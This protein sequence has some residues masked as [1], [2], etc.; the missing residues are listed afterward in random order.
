MNILILDHLSND[1]NY[2]YLQF[3]SGVVLPRYI[4]I[5]IGH[6][7]S[8]E[9]SS[10]WDVS[11]RCI[12]FGHCFKLWSIFLWQSLESAKIHSRSLIFHIHHM[13]SPGFARLNHSHTQVGHGNYALTSIKTARKYIYVFFSNQPVQWLL[14]NASTVTSIVAAMFWDVV[15]SRWL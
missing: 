2:G 1:Q 5:I 12:F 15:S 3:F 13:W 7:D 14:G 10:V 6:Q 4:G 8:F 9:E 11:C